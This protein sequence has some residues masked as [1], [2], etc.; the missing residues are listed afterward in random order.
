MSLA[1]TVRLRNP[2][3]ISLLLSVVLCSTSVMAEDAELANLFSQY[4]VE[5]TIVLSAL[6]QEVTYIHNDARA[7]TRFNPAST[8]KIPNSLIAIE[9]NVLS[10]QYQMCRWDG[11]E[12]SM[13]TWNQDQNLK[14]AFRDSCLWFYQDIA[15][16]VGAHTYQKYLSEMQYGNQAVSPN[17]VRFWLDGDLKISAIE[18]VEFIKSVYRKNLKFSPKTYAVLQDIM[19]NETNTEYDIYAKT[20]F[21]NL[22]KAYQGWYV[23]YVE[24]NDQTWVFATNLQITDPKKELE[25]RKKVTLAALKE[26]GIIY[27]NDLS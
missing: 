1:K 24:S 21:S 15:R 9:E 13:A 7:N 20:G 12:H 3:R 8:F 22:G 2:F 17:L 6:D 23:G 19:L 26:K 16:Q 25:L 4:Q 11:K 27:D 5:G 18:Q 14:T 10:D